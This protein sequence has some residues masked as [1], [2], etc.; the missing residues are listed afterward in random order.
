MTVVAST[1]EN[2]ERD[3]ILDPIL[4]GGLHQVYSRAA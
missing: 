3:R 1:W 4:L 2:D